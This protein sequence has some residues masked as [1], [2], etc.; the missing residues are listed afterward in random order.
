MEKDVLVI[1]SGITGLK[2]ALTLNDLDIGTIII[3]K[4]SKVGGKVKDYSKIFPT[5]SDGKLIIKDLRDK[6]N[7][8]S[9]IELLTGTE[10]HS[11]SRNDG[12]F[13]VT[14]TDNLSLNVRAII[15]AA[16]FDSFDPIKQTEYGYG[17]YPNIV[18]SV[19][20]ESFLDPEGPTAGK[21]LKPSDKKPAKRIAIVFCVGSRNKRIGNPYCSRICCSYSTKQ[22][23]EIKEKD[24]E[25]SVTC[26]YMD[27]RTYGKGFEEM[28]SYAQELG[29]KY[30]RGRVSECSMDLEGNI[31]IRA[32]NTL[33][34]KPMQGNFDLVSLAV[35]M[36]PCADTEKLSR[37]L[38]LE[39]DK[40][41]FLSL[42]DEEFSPHKTSQQ[43]IFL[44]GAVTGLKPIQDCLADGLSVG[45][46]AA[47]YLR[48]KG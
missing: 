35:G 1:G 6:V 46:E 42:A 22:A 27:I 12:R 45:G 34:G 21:V 4:E 2:A 43:G 44:A 9:Y 8:S 47:L 18:T 26:F 13:Q 15:V 24:R 38:N 20:M 33:L 5:F 36:R 23:I 3:E 7:A 17:V 11:V 14:L 48:R 31:Q 25:A 40:D 29:V 28:Y 30:I 32:E 16:G 39:K 37:M 19:E 41:G 10:I